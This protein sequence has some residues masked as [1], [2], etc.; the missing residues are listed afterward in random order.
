MAEEE[1]WSDGRRLC[2]RRGVDVMRLA[3][4]SSVMV[5]E[6]PAASAAPPDAQRTNLAT[7][8]EVSRDFAAS[9]PSPG[10]K[11]RA[12]LP[13]QSPRWRRGRRGHDAIFSFPC[14]CSAT[15]VTATAA[16]PARRT[17]TTTSWR[18]HLSSCSNCP[19][20]PSAS[21][22]PTPTSTPDRRC[23]Y[24]RPFTTGAECAEH[25]V[26]QRGSLLAGEKPWC[27]HVNEGA[28]LPFGKETFSF[29]CFSCLPFF[30]C[31]RQRPQSR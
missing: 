8:E 13:G 6:T 17:T 12:P 24:S 2:Q 11:F 14:S 31:H 26:R 16:T 1:S 10:S 21:A 20:W 18:C 29:F 15:S 19:P 27:A 25:Q 4:S 23:C 30:A 5:C 7:V 3:S 22:P 28:P 9:S